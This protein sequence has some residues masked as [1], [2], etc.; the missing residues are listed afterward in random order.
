[1]ENGFFLQ[2]TPPGLCGFSTRS[3]NLG[4]VVNKVTL[5]QGFSK[6]FGFPFQFMSTNCV[7]FINYPIIDVVEF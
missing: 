5:G 7:T 1:M 3:S 6:Y 4:F 2:S